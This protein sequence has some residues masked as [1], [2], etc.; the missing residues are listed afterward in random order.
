MF[1]GFNCNCHNILLVQALLPNENTESYVW[2]F[3][4]ILKATDE[5]S[6]VIITDT[7][8]TIDSTVCQNSLASNYENFI[9]AFY[10]CRNSLTK[11]TFE[12]RFEDLH[13]NFPGTKKILMP[14]I[15][16]KQRNEIN[17]SVYYKVSKLLDDDIKRL[18]SNNQKIEIS[19]ALVADI[20]QILL[21][22][23]IHLVEELN[24]VIEV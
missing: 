4:E 24:N 1:V 11:E 5:Q 8:S 6:A 12:R 20:Q 23:L 10:I 17:Q 3:K 13:Q 21:K 16:Q 19:D 7:D 22:E 14:I 9:E 2:M 15:L 18:C